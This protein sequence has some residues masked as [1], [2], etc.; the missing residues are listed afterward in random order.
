[1]EPQ[2]VV[3][4][5]EL[6][7]NMHTIK[8]AGT[9]GL[10]P[11][12][13]VSLLRVK[14]GDK[15]EKGQLLAETK[16]LLGRFM[17]Q[18]ISAPIGG[19]VE[20]FSDVSGNLGI[21]AAPIP[22][23]KT[24]YL[25]GS[26]TKVMPGDGVEV[27]TQGAFVQG[28]FG[29]GGERQGLLSTVV[30]GPDEVLDA[31][32]VT[33]DAR[34]KILV[35]GSIVTAEGLAAARKAGAAAIVVGG[36]LDQDL[37]RFLGHEI[38]VAITGHEDLDLTLI[39]TEGFGRITMAKR[40]FDLLRSLEGQS[41]SVNGATQIRAGVIRPEVIVPLSAPP[42]SSG[43][44]PSAPDGNSLEIGTPIRLIREPYFG[45][46]ATVSGLPPELQQ[47]PSGAVVRV[48]KARL[49]EG[50]EV[51]VPRANVEIVGS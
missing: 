10:E 26:I 14:V 45:R 43:S 9:L 6:P 28:I 50:E 48:L 41:A 23:E 31:A 13:V 39:L 42:A 8:V 29:V 15:V 40:T 49:A 34:G 35:G 32:K 21:R 37:I 51:T 25:A 24:A 30:S 36:I 46:L 4:R 12:D 19:T 33:P 16:G 44:A 22:V 11:G 47:V 38:G 18:T 27:E 17:K 3:A 2:T 5:A 20:H 7:G 1:V